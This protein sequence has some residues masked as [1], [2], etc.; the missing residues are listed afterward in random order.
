MLGNEHQLAEKYRRNEKTVT[1]TFLLM[2]TNK[3]IHE[4]LQYMNV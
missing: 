3:N 4:L 1:V 2:I